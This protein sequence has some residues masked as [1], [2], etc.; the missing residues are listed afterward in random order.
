M[1][2]GKTLI[3]LAVV[4]ATKGHW[5]EV[6][7]E[8]SLGRHPVRHKVGTLAEMAASAIGRARIPWR[9]YFQDLAKAGE[10]HD[11][12]IALLEQNIGSYIIPS[13]QMRPSRNASTAATLQRIRLCTATLIVVPLNL[14][15]QWQNEI[16][17]HVE[18]DTLS[19][20][21]V[22]ALDTLFPSIDELLN[23]DIVLIS[24][25]RFEREMKPLEIN[26]TTSKRNIQCI[27]SAT[28]NCSC[29]A[30][31]PSY[32]SPLRKLH[33]LRI[34]V[35]EGHQFASSGGT[36]NMM[37]GLQR[38]RVDRRWIVSGTPS[39]GLI[40]AVSCNQVSGS[41]RLACQKTLIS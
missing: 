34:I 22:Q 38:L 5:P 4:L 29:A 26:P 1:G 6:P 31:G 14:F 40:G 9:T 27:C 12:C 23:C 3:C 25:E 39:A 17:A 37:W 7:P 35:D 41:G 28:D 18:E 21:A 11:R 36:N 16:S 20:L 13:S 33:F 2:F 30:A 19:I 8:Y 24:K 32:H 15:T 10:Y